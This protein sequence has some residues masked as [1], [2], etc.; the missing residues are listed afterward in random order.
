M[1]CLDNLQKGEHQHA[2]IAYRRGLARHQHDLAAPNAR[3][4]NLAL[5]YVRRHHRGHQACRHAFAAC[6]VC[7]KHH[8]GV[9]HS[10]R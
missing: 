1:L 4:R 9:R 2:S 10:L 7:Q 5:H 3:R 6:A 8:H